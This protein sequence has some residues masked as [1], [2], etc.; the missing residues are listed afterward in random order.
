MDDSVSGY[1]VEYMVR[2]IWISMQV[3]MIMDVFMQSLMKYNVSISASFM[4]FLRKVTGSNVAAGVAGSIAL[5]DTKFK[6]LKTTLKI[7]KKVVMAAISW[8]TTATNA[9]KD[10]KKG[11]AK[12]YQANPTL[13][14]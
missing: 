5:L 13:K 9:T 14:K 1:R 12:L 4:Q 2:C 10:T 3:H 8:A 7:V 11:F 6:N